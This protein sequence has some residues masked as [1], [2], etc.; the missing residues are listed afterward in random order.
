MA[1]IRRNTLRAKS[2]ERRVDALTNTR[3][4]RQHGGGPDDL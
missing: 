1:T 3:M 2:K 4:I